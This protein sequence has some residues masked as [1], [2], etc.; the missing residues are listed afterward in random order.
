MTAL[1]QTLRARTISE[2]I[3]SN[4]RSPTDEEISY[5]LRK[6][7]KSYP[8][9]NRTGFGR[10]DM[11]EPAFHAPSSLVAEQG[12][13]K[14]NFDDLFSIYQEVSE[15]GIILDSSNR[16]FNANLDRISKSLD[17]L[18]SRADTLLLQNSTTDQFVWSVEETLSDQLKVLQTDCFID[19]G[20]AM[21]ATDRIEVLD[22]VEYRFTHTVIGN[23]VTSIQTQGSLEN[24][25]YIDG[26]YWQV[27]A[28]T[29]DIQPVTLQLTIQLD[30][31]TDIGS[32]VIVLNS[33]NQN[34]QSFISVL[35]SKDK[36]NFSLQVDR[37]AT[38]SRENR[39]NLDLTNIKA[40]KVLVHKSKPDE[41]KSNSNLY[42][43]EFDYIQIG[44][45]HSDIIENSITCG[46][47]QI[48]DPSGNL[49]YP[50]KATLN[51][52]GYKPTGTDIDFYLSQDN[53]VWTPIEPGNLNI[54]S[55]ARGDKAGTYSLIE[56]GLT[57][58]ELTQT[59]VEGLSIRKNS[60]ALI[61]LKIDSAFSNLVNQRTIIVKRNLPGTAVRSL[62]S[63]WSEK[64]NEYSCV[65]YVDAPEGQKI[66]LGPTSAYLNERLV[67][68][69]VVL[70]NGYS[71]F[72]TSDANWRSI[73]SFSSLEDLKRQ[74]SLYPFNHKL[75]IE[76]LTYPNGW[77]AERVYEGADSYFGDFLEFVPPEVFSQSPDLGI[78]TIYTQDS[79]MYFKVYID[80][81]YSDW[82]NELFEVDYTVQKNTV[83]D[84]YFRAVLKTDTG[85]SPILDSVQIRVV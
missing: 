20:R 50:S 57:E 41:I 66:H 51:Y 5:Y 67:T 77:T 37:V 23:T 16:A 69:D 21:I 49:I 71:T 15:L 22:P 34:S 7:K 55:F 42:H 48:K 73:S 30:N 47:Y 11:V 63:G 64:D 44:Q 61:N 81:T 39:F 83:S 75:L 56:A 17:N 18:E 8:E 60:E 53:D 3:Q 36:E 65:L 1:D 26:S 38:L 52:C 33:V 46:P 14:A 19:S 85:V 80:K 59:E 58:Q 4:G 54:V 76:G 32:L 12:N 28:K 74:D 2:F 24:L 72:R 84:I 29:R 10:V 45:K 79:Q 13:R 82:D 9:L 68:G 6:T 31:K 25:K 78:Y 43:F 70:E 35:S 40:L 27:T 62:E